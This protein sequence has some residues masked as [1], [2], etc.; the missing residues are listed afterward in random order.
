[1]TGPRESH[2]TPLGW[3]VIGTG[4]VSEAV[5]ADL[6][7][8]ADSG[9]RRTAV[10]SRSAQTGAAF[11][12]ECGFDR[13]YSDY[14]AL[15]ADAE[16]D[17]VYIATPHATHADLAEQALR[18]GKHVLIEKPIGTNAAEAVRI[19]HVAGECDRFAG[20]AMWMRYNPAYRD[21]LD[22]LRADAIGTVRSVRASFGLPFDRPDSVR[23]TAERGSSTL[24]D[25]AIYPVTLA[26]D[27]LGMPDRVDA[28]GTRREDG[29]D[30]DE[31][32]TFEY[33]DGRF[34][35]L[36]ASMTDFVEPSASVNGRDGW[37]TIDA[38]FWASS[39]FRLHAGSIGRALTEPEHIAHDRRGNGYVPMLEAVSQAVVGGL[40]QHPIHSLTASIAILEVLDRIR[41]VMR[42]PSR[43]EKENS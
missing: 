27:I 11:A 31:H 5:S 19:A 38:P 17:L 42:S 41:H 24:L 22:R 28:S 35:Q 32:I 33:T 15:L 12:E 1:M 20:E 16:I 36:A 14:G 39:S 34:A 8:L 26:L 13:Y 23:W 18:A 7:E 10:H 43:P 3:A 2:P 30:L 29:V 25:Q 40:R 6:S 4:A 9:V 21:A 37:L